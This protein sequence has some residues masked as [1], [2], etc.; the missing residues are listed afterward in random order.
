MVKKMNKDILELRKDMEELVQNVLE[1]ALDEIDIQNGRIEKYVS[2]LDHFNNIIDLSGRKMMDASL[3]TQIGAMKLD[4]L[5]NKMSISKQTMEGLLEATNLAQEAL[6]KRRADDDETSVKFWENQVEVLKREL[7]AAQETFL[8]NWEETLQTAGDIFDMRVELAVQTM[9][10]A[11]SPFSSMDVFSEM[12]TREKEIADQYLDDATKLYELNKL[13]RQLNLSIKDENDLLA[14]SKLRDLQEEIYA[15]QKAGVD[16]SQYDLEILQKKYDLRLAEI[17]LMEAQNS[18]TSM[19]LVRDAA[20]N[21]TYAYDADEQKIEDATQKYED[22]M[23]EMTK[24]SNEYMDEMSQQ[25]IDIQ[26]EYMEA[27]NNVDKNAS[28]YQYQLIRIQ[29]QYMERYRFTLSELKKST[30]DLGLTM[31]DTLYGSQMDLWSF[32]DAQDRF[33][34]N[35]DLTLSELM[36]NYKDWQAIVEKAMNVAGTSWDSFGTDMDGTLG[37]LE[38]HIQA[39]CDEISELVDVLMGYVAQAIGMVEEWQAKYSKQVDAELAKNEGY[40]DSRYH[41]S[42]SGSGGSKIK[43]NTDYSNLIYRLGKGETVTIDGVEYGV[44]KGNVNEGINLAGNKRENKLDN[45]SSSQASQIVKDHGATQDFVDAA[46]KNLNK[47]A[48][49]ATGMYT[50][51]WSNSEGMDGMGGKL[52]ILHQKE[53]VLNKSDTKNILEAVEL[54]RKN[55]PQ[56]ISKKIDEL[57]E[58][59]QNQTSYTFNNLLTQVKLP[60]GPNPQELLQNVEIYADFPGVTDQ[61][62]IREAFNN[63]SNEAS[64]YLGIKNRF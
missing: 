5:I 47:A 12:Y 32:E 48:S 33:T 9:S 28:D 8:A 1:L 60:L 13:N 36:T 34:A 38:E 61:N 37:S 57:V 26:V 51:D 2:M 18:K 64:Q 3:K 17:A 19:R 11:L 30:E 16:M 15:L 29:E 53:L 7:E 39:L 4:T 58:A 52:A 49:G 55:Q 6:E 45:M 43:D 24:K 62:E 44:S 27:L 59:M 50:G 40:M 10:D 41:Q 46:I 23:Y 22:A 35:S 63:L 20:G 14:Q 21:W 56:Q 42:G 54:A 25:L 31:H